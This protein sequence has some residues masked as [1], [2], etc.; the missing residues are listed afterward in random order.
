MAMKLDDP[1]PQEG[2]PPEA[3][4]PGAPA[5]AQPKKKNGTY[6]ANLAA[7]VIACAAAVAFFRIH[8]EP[9]FDQVA[10]VGGTVSFWALL[11]MG[12]TAFEKSSKTDAWDLSRRLISSTELSRVLLATIAALAALWFTTGSQYFEY[13]GPG[14][15]GSSFTV[16]VLKDDAA[17]H[18]LPVAERKSFAA[19]AVLTPNERLQGRGF[20]WRLS[21]TP[22]L[23]M[24]EKKGVPYEPRDCSIRPGSSTRTK[25]PGDFR[26]KNVHL[27]RIIPSIP[28]FTMLPNA[29]SEKQSTF[30]RLTL[31]TDGQMQ[32]VDDLRRGVL[33]LGGKADEMDELRAMQSDDE[34][35][36]TIRSALL[37]KG[38]QAA[39]AEQTT[40]ILARNQQ[41][42]SLRL[43]Q[44]QKLTL[45]LEQVV[46]D[47]GHESV[48]PVTG[49]P[50]SVVITSEKVQSVWLPGN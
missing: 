12:W 33:L 24:L 41:P 19:D 25:V 17:N 46:V 27:I 6:F 13:D 48:A 44:G 7:L 29:E 23:C 5:P 4:A 36:S 43:D 18:A 16:H 39:S 50:F 15:T 42:R 10:L 40:A 31:K 47:G 9:Y 1:D 35:K 38:I 32:Q 3:S 28:A 30:Y 34:L 8:L 14:A 21:A 26:L 11:K 49:Y 22:L 20:F 45:L 2:A 37:A